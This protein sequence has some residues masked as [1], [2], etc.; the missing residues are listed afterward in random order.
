M[1]SYKDLEIYNASYQLALQAHTISLKLPTYELYETGSQLRRAP[2]SITANIVE[3]YG[4]KRYKNDFVKFLTYSQASCDETL[5]HLSFIT[6]LYP[7]IKEAAET[8]KT[9]YD[10]LGKK[11]YNFIRFVEGKWKT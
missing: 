10:E 3:G 8:L 9:K 7:D 2:K 6:D 4:R 11:L 5:L 1:N